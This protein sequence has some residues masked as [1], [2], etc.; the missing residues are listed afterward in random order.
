MSAPVNDSAAITPP[1]TGGKHNSAY[2]QQVISVLTVACVLMLCVAKLT[3][4]LISGSATVLSSF[5]DSL[6]DIG[7]SIMTLLSLRFAAKPPDEEHREGHGKIEGVAALL[8]A[9]FIAGAGA[10]LVLESV[11]RLFE[12][13]TL[14]NQDIAFWVLLGSTILSFVM[15]AAQR[16]AMKFHDSMALEADHAHYATDVYINLAATAVLFLDAQ[17]I[18]PIWLDPLAALMIAG[19]MARTS[20][21]IAFR[22]L[23]MLLD[24][25]VPAE[26]RAAISFI[27]MQQ[28]D[29]KDYHDLRTRMIGQRMAISFDLAVDAELSLREAHNI[30]RRVELALLDAYPLASILIHV[31]PD[32]DTHDTRHA[33][34]IG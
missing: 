21:K 8:Q 27:I 32:D 26:T 9:A 31:D 4:Y 11:S 34:F 13:R 3:A 2:I 7:L 33:G 28:P 12:P 22:S 29:V 1:S 10:L 20:L 23:D 25:E 6:T 17:G 14:D 24:R 15:A 30:A 5:L 18:A 19:L 16:W